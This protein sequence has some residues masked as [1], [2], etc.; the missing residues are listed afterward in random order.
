FTLVAIS[1]SGARNV[2]YQGI[3]CAA[4]EHKIY[5]LGQADGTWSRARRDQWD[6]IINNAMNRQQ[7]AL[8]G[9]Y[10]CRGGGVAGKL[11]DMLRRL[12]Q[13]EVLN[14]DLLN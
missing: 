4:N 14:K 3:R 12:R 13:R 9:D 5:A 8:A 7:A 11:P 6:P 1:T 2:S 10:F